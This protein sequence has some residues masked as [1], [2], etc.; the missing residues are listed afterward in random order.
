[1]TDEQN[2]FLTKPFEVHEIKEAIFS[3]HPDKAL[4]PDEMNPCFFQQFWDL[5][6]NEVTEPVFLTSTIVLCLQ[7]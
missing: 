1:M 5:V 2:E 7:A 3:M 4:G 6:G